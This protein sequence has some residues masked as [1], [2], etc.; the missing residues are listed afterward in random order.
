MTIHPIIE[1][2]V[3]RCHVSESN[4]AVIKYVIS[5][6]RKGYDTFRAMPK[7]D[8]KTMMRMCIYVHSENRSL[9]NLVMR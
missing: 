2:C 3:N 1:Q 6:L 8:R 5:R 4:R 9:Y 7:K